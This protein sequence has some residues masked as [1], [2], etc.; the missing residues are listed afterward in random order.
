LISEICLLSLR[1][2]ACPLILFGGE[3][4]AKIKPGTTID[5]VIGRER[6]EL[7]SR[8]LK[9]REEAEAYARAHGE[10]EI[11]RTVLRE[12]EDG[13]WDEVRTDWFKVRGKVVALLK[14]EHE[15]RGPGTFVRAHAECLTCGAR[16]DSPSSSGV[17]DWAL[18]HRM[19]EWD[20]A[21][22]VRTW[23]TQRNKP[24]ECF[25]LQKEVPITKNVSMFVAIDNPDPE[26][27]T[28]DQDNDE[29]E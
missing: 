13:F 1:R 2:P 22:E 29:E 28:A 9:S 23:E 4:V 16:K 24:G 27:A 19:W 20:R 15:E 26:P 25:P 14:E 12:G 3:T 7:P 5:W 8:D 21:H 10:K 11:G 6:R 18:L 17:Y